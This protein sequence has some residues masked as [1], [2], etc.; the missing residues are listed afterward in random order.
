MMVN[1]FKKS[2]NTRAKLN[3]LKKSSPWKLNLAFAIIVILS[4]FAVTYIAF[5][6]ISRSMVEQAQN[7]SKELIR[8]TTKNLKTV[9][10]GVD[11]IA[12]MI[13]RD[14]VVSECV[15]NINNTQDPYV[16]GSNMR[17][18]EEILNNNAIT[19]SY[20]SDIGVI[21]NN[22]IYISSGQQKPYKQYDALQYYPAKIY[23]ESQKKSFWLDTYRSDVD[24]TRRNSVNGQV[25]S[26]VKGIYSL[27]RIASQGLL[28]VNIK[29]SYLYGLMSDIK[30]SEGNVFIVSSGG[31]YVLNPNNRDQNG[32]KIGKS[33]I[34]DVLKRKNGS[35]IIPI[36][37]KYFIVTY[38]TINDINGTE[39]GWTV[40]GMTPVDYVI[41][42]IKNTAQKFAL[43]GFLSIF[44]GFIL[45]VLVTKFY[46]SFIQRKYS[47]EHMVL[48]ERERLASLGQLI[49]GIAHNFKTPIMSIAGGLE[50]LKD[51]ADE[52]EISIGDKE[53]TE[54]DHREIAKEMKIWVEN[55]KPY[56]GYMS[57]IISAVKGQA[58]NL[59]ES[60]NI[61]FTLDEL[62][63][64]VNILMDHELKK[65]QCKMD[66]ELKTD[67]ETQIQGE[68]NNLVQVINNMISN[69][70]E[71]YNGQKGQIHLN[72]DKKGNDIVISIKDNGCG[73]PENVK[74]KLLKEMITTKGKNG[75]GLGLYMSYSTI[76][77]KFGGDINIVS[78]EGNGTEIVISIPVYK[79]NSKKSQD[80]KKN[81]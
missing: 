33:Y 34:H 44:M 22:G 57:D 53:V 5:T 41:E 32:S 79:G 62:I 8:Q 21:T 55:I 81:N 46:S 30:D 2:Q 1:L 3:P 36:E 47:E 35:E 23:K 65:N 11:D 13:S 69:S 16:R 74:K 10:A 70:I 54:D 80:S 39:L 67:P 6:M 63:K 40:I 15:I 45:T 28:I 14:S 75:T 17:S 12:M 25:F 37:G 18:I 38:N 60:T 20:M 73:I 29:E 48:L 76:K 19:R 27:K 61:N 4:I 58:V 9:L 49:G 71:S 56:C 52:Y 68:V 72:I 24:S 78:E 42:D 50:A 51:L 77:G 31:N 59:N 7:S 26:I 43:V 64:R 66:L